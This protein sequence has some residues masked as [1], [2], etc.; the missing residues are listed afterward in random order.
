MFVRS[1]DGDE[2]GQPV[3]VSETVSQLAVRAVI[4]C[5]LCTYVFVSSCAVNPHTGSGVAATY[6][7]RVWV[8]PI[9]Y[10]P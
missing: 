8:S 1:D 3:I 4:L 6:C 10:I 5:I 2:R 7:S 9:L